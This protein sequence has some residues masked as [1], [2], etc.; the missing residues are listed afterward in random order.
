[1]VYWLPKFG[2]QINQNLVKRNSWLIPNTRFLQTIS[3]APDA[4]A[5]EVICGVPPD[6]PASSNMILDDSDKQP[7]LMCPGTKAVYK[8]NTDGLNVRQVIS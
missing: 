5:D 6:A 3:A 8:C 4:I 1:M 2:L 7:D